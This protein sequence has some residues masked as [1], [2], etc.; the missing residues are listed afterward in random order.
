MMS[1]RPGPMKLRTSSRIII[2]LSAFGMML[3]LYN[4]THLPESILAMDDSQRLRRL[5]PV[6]AVFLGSLLCIISII[7]S[8]RKDGS[9]R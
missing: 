1:Q 4:L 3:S 9:Q 6:G 2:L 8:G 5:V 7:V